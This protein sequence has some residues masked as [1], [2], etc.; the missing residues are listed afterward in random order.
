MNISRNPDIEA[1]VTFIPT[2]QGGRTK[3]A[4][5]NY[6]V[7][8]DFGIPG[9]LNVAQHEFVNCDEAVPGKTVKSRLWFMAPELQK[10][11]LHPGFKFTVQESSRVV[12]HGVIVSVLNEALNSG[13]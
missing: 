9:T 6:R 11:R 7:D 4:W 13:A 5:Q 2:E 3:A 10:G 1:E 8:H 12:A